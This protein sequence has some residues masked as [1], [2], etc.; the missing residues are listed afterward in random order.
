[1]ALNAGL[2]TAEAALT[3]L[4]LGEYQ[5][6]AAST[7]A[8][9]TVADDAAMAATR[10]QAKSGSS[11]GEVATFFP[12]SNGFLGQADDAFLYAG[13]K[14]DRYGGGDWLRFFSPKGTPDFTRALPP[15]TSGQP[16]K[17]FEV[18]KP[19]PVKSGQVAPAF[20]Q[21]GG[22]IQY[23]APVKLKTLIERGFLR[24]LP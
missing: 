5:A 15:G 2:M 14:I 19:F 22:G 13:Q 4:T 20:G 23:V 21:M 10:T 8:A 3:A 6:Y 24:E 11:I 16:L 9:A 17:T 18:T 7:R 1:M 12:G